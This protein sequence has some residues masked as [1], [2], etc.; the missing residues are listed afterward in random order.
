MGSIRQLCKKGIVLEKG[1]IV[2]SS[3]VHSAVDYYL[4]NGHDL[5]KESSVVVMEEQHDKNRSMLVQFVS[6]SFTK[7]APIFSSVALEL[8]SAPEPP[9]EELGAIEFST[10][11]WQSPDY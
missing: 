9:L 10:P 7:G 6:F 1:R 4:E 3:D 2:H 5:K 11:I 8:Q